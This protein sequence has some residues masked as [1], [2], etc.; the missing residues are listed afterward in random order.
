MQ[1]ALNL[2]VGYP[3]PKRTMTMMSYF[4]SLLISK[5]MSDVDMSGQNPL[6]QFLRNKSVT[7]WRRHFPAAS[8]QQIPNINDKS[9]TSP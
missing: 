6:H 2:G 7:S 1:T 4:T 5:M 8:P 9:V 3:K